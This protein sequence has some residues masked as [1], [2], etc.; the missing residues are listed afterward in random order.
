MRLADLILSSVDDGLF[1]LC[2]SDHLLAE[3][4][5]V[6]IDH[7]GLPADK[8]KIFREAVEANASSVMRAGEYDNNEI[9]ITVFVGDPFGV[10][11]GTDGDESDP[12]GW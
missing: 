12:P 6:L 1:E 11:R 2:V 4:E 8:A 3:I 7:K 5:R 9:K 10:C